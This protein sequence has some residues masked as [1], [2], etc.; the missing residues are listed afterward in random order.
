MTTKFLP[1]FAAMIAAYS[2]SSNAVAQDATPTLSVEFGELSLTT[3]SDEGACS[4]TDENCNILDAGTGFIQRQ[5]DV[6]GKR[7]IQTVISGPFESEDVIQIVY[8][9]TGAGINGVASKLTLNGGDT[10]KD[11]DI[12]NEGIHTIAVSPTYSGWAHNDSSEVATITADVGGN[13]NA[14][15]VEQ[16]ITGKGS[17]GASDLADIDDESATSSNVVPPV[18]SLSDKGPFG[19]NTAPPLPFENIE[20]ATSPQMLSAGDNHSLWIKNDGTL[21]AWGSNTQ[22]VLGLGEDVKYTAQPMQVGNDRWQFVTTRGLCSYGIKEGGTLWA[23][24]HQ[25]TCL[26]STDDFST[27]WEP[28]KAIGSQ[29]KKFSLGR[30]YAAAIRLDGSLVIWKRGANLVNQTVVHQRDDWQY[31]SA[32]PETLFAI[33]EDGT[34]WGWGANNNYQ[35]G[36]GT[37]DKASSLVLIS[38][39]KW[40]Q[41]EA[42][43]GN[44]LSR[45]IRD[46]GTLWAW[47]YNANGYFGD[48]TGQTLTTPTQI[49]Q[50]RWWTIDSGAGIKADGTLWTWGE[51]TYGQIGDGT[52]EAKKDP[53]QIGKDKWLYISTGAHFRIGRSSSPARPQNPGAA[54]HH[55][56]LRSRRRG[57]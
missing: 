41:V 25:T 32:G 28:M 45:A 15:Q 57:R 11:V 9:N 26:L 53:V 29:W 44:T 5:I 38:S 1:L 13:I 27:E 43:N 7:Y 24:G 35:L 30:S 36:N 40:I 22:G 3:T 4:T 37:T 12:V 8:G 42:G 16:S 47:G 18:D 56:D 39:D 55:P 48:N 20:V 6:G 49:G 2:L 46:D 14:V 54:R 34:L 17:F 50:D 33:K 51:N 23:W 10:T 31:I 52:V 19:W 21:W